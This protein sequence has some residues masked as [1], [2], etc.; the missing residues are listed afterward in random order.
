MAWR[1]L[2]V[3]AWVLLW[4]GF[5]ICQVLECNRLSGYCINSIP[6]FHARSRIFSG[7]CSLCRTPRHFCEPQLFDY[8]MIAFK[9]LLF[10]INKGGS[11]RSP[12]PISRY[13]KTRCKRPWP[14]HT[15]GEMRQS[16]SQR[17]DRNGLP[18]LPRADLA[19][20]QVKSTYQNLKKHMHTTKAPLKS[21]LSKI[22][23]K[24]RANK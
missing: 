11:L 16:A 22:L 1:H 14:I 5:E 19:N 23:Q 17:S 12:K 8:I 15:A 24:G 3:C 20:H 2:P 7:L 9:L 18:S 21:N 6:L 13:G 10:L 4:E